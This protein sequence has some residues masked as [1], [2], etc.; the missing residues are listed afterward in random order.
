VEEL[1]VPESFLKIERFIPQKNFVLTIGG[2][3]FF[4]GEAFFEKLW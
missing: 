3:R 1:S 2:S 4:S